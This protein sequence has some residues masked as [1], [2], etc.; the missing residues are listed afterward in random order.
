LVLAL[1]GEPF[2]PYRKADFSPKRG[3]SDDGWKRRIALEF[4]LIRVGKP[5]R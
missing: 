1:Q 2:D 4:D 5:R 3:K